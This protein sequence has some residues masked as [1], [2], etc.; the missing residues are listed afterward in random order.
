[1]AL[2]PPQTHCPRI[3]QHT[4][5]SGWS[6]GTRLLS[7]RRILSSSKPHRH[8]QTCLLKMAIYV[9]CENKVPILARLCKI[10]KSLKPSV[11]SGAVVEVV[12][13]AEETPGHFRIGLKPRRIR[14]LL[15][16]ES[17]L[18]E[19]RVGSPESFRPAEVGQTGVNTHSFSNK[20]SWS[21]ELTRAGCDNKGAAV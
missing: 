2:H 19:R 11:R 15:K 21:S 5:G 8:V 7:A 18:F 16:F 3:G 17:Q 20:S 12:S 13:V 4:E 1:M 10:E 14:N 9:R 6:H